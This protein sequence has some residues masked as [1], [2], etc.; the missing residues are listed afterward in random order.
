M[1]RRPVILSAVGVAALAGVALAQG[2]SASPAADTA[3]P[4]MT[5]ARRAPASDTATGSVRPTETDDA[6]NAV[7][8]ASWRAGQA[9]SGVTPAA[10]HQ[11]Q[12]H[13]VCSA[14]ASGGADE[15]VVRLMQREW[16]RIVYPRDG[17][18]L[19]DWR[20]G[21]RLVRADGTADTHAPDPAS[22]TLRG[23]ACMGCH[24]LGGRSPPLVAASGP[25]LDQYGRLRGF[26]EAEP[27]LLYERLWNA[28][29][30]TPCSVM[31]RFGANGVLTPAQIKDIIAFLLAPDSPLNAAPAPTDRA[32]QPP[33]K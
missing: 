12:A 6:L 10:L 22:E 18:Y 24:A 4:V 11:D 28:Q 21:E 26:G 23:G 19:G 5:D 13:R 33:S 32:V 29:A 3:R 30:L 20:R 31:P 1:S 9:S 8:A 7:L 14:H 17:D 15:L 16:S 2:K 25:P 27:K